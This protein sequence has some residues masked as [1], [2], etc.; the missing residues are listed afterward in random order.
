M[1]TAMEYAFRSSALE[2]GET[3]FR[4]TETTLEMNRPGFHSA[5]PYSEISKVRL[6]HD[7]SRFAMNK[8]QCEITLRTSATL[9]LK[10]VHYRGI[11]DFEDRGQLYSDFIR[12]FHQRLTDYPDVTY[13]S[14]NNPGCFAGNLIITVGSIILLIVVF[15]YM[16]APTTFGSIFKLLVVGVMSIYTIQYLRKNKPATYSPDQI[17]ERI[18][19]K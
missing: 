2:K 17:P 11:A 4:L 9:I 14:G 8:Y 1:K 7:P 3:T 19:P 12:E 13:H 6:Y 18:L 15:M 10:S 5:V 16:G